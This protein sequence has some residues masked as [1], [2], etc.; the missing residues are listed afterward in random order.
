MFNNMRLLGDNRDWNLPFRLKWKVKR[1]SRYNNMRQQK[2]LVL[3]SGNKKNPPKLQ[4]HFLGLLPKGSTTVSK[5]QYYNN[6][7]YNYNVISHNSHICERFS[8]RGGK[9]RCLWRTVRADTPRARALKEAG[10]PGAQIRTDLPVHA[11]KWATASYL[12]AMGP[13]TPTSDS[14]CRLC[15][16]CGRPPWSS[17]SGCSCGIMKNL[18]LTGL[19]LKLKRT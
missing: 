14:L 17:S 18:T 19:N 15:A 13:K 10:L 11:R 7:L 9:S 3:V 12:T 8:C 1:Y 16:L 4:D 5:P 6:T 2:N